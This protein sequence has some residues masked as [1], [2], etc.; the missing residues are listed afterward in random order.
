MFFWF[1]LKSLV[2]ISE[3]GDLLFASLE[4]GYTIISMSELNDAYK[5]PLRWGFLFFLINCFCFNFFLYFCYKL[6]N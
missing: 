2:S 1:I 3:K 6:I 4:D 5:N